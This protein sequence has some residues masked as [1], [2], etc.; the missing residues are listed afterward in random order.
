MLK[1]HTK[2]VYKSTIIISFFKLVAR[3]VRLSTRAGL[4]SVSPFN[5]GFGFIS[6]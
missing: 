2:L 5:R 4:V 1:S 6:G 3:S